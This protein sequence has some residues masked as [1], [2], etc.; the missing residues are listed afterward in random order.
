[1]DY[2][3]PSSGGGEALAALLAIYVIVIVVS[4]LVVLAFYVIM[5]FALMS[6]FR[7]V[8]VKPWIAW[9]PYYN[10][11]VWLQIGG[12]QGWLALLALIPYGGIA[13]AIFLYI[14][15]YRTGVG[16]RKGGEW[17]VLG[18]FLPFVWAFL[19]GRR[20]EVYDPSLITARGY[21]SPLAGFGSAPN[22]ANSGEPGSP[23]PSPAAPPATPGV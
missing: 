17:V 6:F 18:I 8:G 3:D 2:D 11:W 4:L 7:K 15:M 5:S 14:G 21:P 23:A 20:T 1:M 19:L 9:V 10:N 13:T 16:F 22:W 12:Q